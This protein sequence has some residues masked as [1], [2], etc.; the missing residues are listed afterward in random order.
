[1]EATLPLEQMN[2]RE[3]LQAI[4]ILWNDLC[5]NV[6]DVPVP[7]WHRDCLFETKKRSAKGQESPLDWEDAKKLLRQRFE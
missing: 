3:K 1:M 6:E 5:R 4:E 2:T 7:Q